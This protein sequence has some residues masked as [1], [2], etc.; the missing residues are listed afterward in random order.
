MRLQPALLLQTRHRRRQQRPQDRRNQW[1][2]LVRLLFKRDLQGTVWHHHHG[3]V[4]RILHS[5]E[6]GTVDVPP[7]LWNKQSLSRARN[8]LLFHLS[9]L[10]CAGTTTLPPSPL[11][12]TARC[13]AL[14]LDS[15][16]LPGSCKRTEA[17]GTSAASGCHSQGRQ[18]RIEKERKGDSFQSGLFSFRGGEGK[19]RIS[20]YSPAFFRESGSQNF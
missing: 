2:G 16:P 3:K 11:R 4:G 13:S 20:L 19:D 6:H 17:S 7:T 9:P 1:R 5:V 18:V 12:Q 10:C 15:G 8:L 14:A